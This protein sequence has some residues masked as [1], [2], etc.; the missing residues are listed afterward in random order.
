LAEKPQDTVRELQALVV[1]YAKQETIEPIKGLGR[2]AGFGI[3]GATLLGLGV[4]FLAI[5][6]LRLLQDETGTT[7][8]GAWSFVPYVIVI[9]VSGIVAALVWTARGKRK[10]KTSA[11][12]S[13]T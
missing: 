7:F 6:L 11:A 2:Y 10:A 4:V 3:A 9:A 5:G 8:T 1:A 12:R 13:T